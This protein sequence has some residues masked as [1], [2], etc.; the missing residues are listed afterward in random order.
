MELS[1]NVQICGLTGLIQLKTM[2]IHEL[3]KL[4]LVQ[5]IQFG[6]EVNMSNLRSRLAKDAGQY[7]MSNNNRYFLEK[8]PLHLIKKID[9]WDYQIPD[10]GLIGDHY[11]NAMVVPKNENK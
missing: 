8:L 5:S 9:S 11:D 6:K 3:K 2:L 10:T 1:N 4:I 7:S